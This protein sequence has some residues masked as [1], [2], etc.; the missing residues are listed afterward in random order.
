MKSLKEWPH[1][2][3]GAAGDDI[4]CGYDIAIEALGERANADNSSLIAMTYLYRR[5]GPP[6]IEEDD[7]KEVCTYLLT[8]ADP[9]VW[10]GLRIKGV[11]LA[12][13]VFYIADKSLREEA[14]KPHAEAEK[15]FRQFWLSKNRHFSDV[16]S[17]NAASAYWKWRFSDRFTVDIQ[18]LSLPPIPSG[19]WKEKGGVY[20]RINQALFDGLQELLRPTYIRDV[21]IN[22]FGVC[23]NTDELGE[24][25]EYWS[26]QDEQAVTL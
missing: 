22:L 23:G 5:F 1:E 7:Y 17:E 11:G 10:L 9:Q 15:I 25:V 20:S 3:Y 8:T 2:S 16:D 24:S 12:Y 4:V 6:V 26:N 21:Y 19:H 13:G 14:Y 18:A